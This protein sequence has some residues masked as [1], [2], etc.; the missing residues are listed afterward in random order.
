MTITQPEEN[1]QKVS[2]LNQIIIGSQWCK[3]QTFEQ[4]TFHTS[5]IIVFLLASFNGDNHF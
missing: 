2:W 5:T 4:E 3:E 1:V